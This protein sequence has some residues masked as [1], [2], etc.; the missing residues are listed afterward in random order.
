MCKDV[1]NSQAKPDTARLLQ[2]Q[3]HDYIANNHR[4]AHSYIARKKFNINQAHTG[5]VSHTHTKA[6]KGT[7]NQVQNQIF[8]KCS[9]TRYNQANTVTKPG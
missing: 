3:S 6:N 1:F 7:N 4:K 8:S 5:K 2:P 9:I